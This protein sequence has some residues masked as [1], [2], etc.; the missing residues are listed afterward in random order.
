VRA[1]REEQARARL[2]VD[3]LQRAAL[4]AALPTAPA[5]RFDAEYSPATSELVVGGDWYDVIDVGEGRYALVIA[6]VA[7]HGMPAAV[8]MVQVRNWLHA[9]ALAVGGS[10]PGTV[11]TMLNRTVAVL[12]QPFVTCC[13]AVVDPDRDEIRWAVAGH[14][15]PLVAG[16]KSCRLLTHPAVGPPLGVVV[17][18]AYRTS[19][20]RLSPGEALVLY[21]D[22][23]VERREEPLDVGFERLRQA[24]A[25]MPSDRLS[26]PYLLSALLGPAG[27]ADDVAVVLV[28]RTAATA[29]G[30]VGTEVRATPAP[31]GGR[32]R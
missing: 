16:P 22:G 12:D 5:L 25:G 10:D 13:M 14:P 6:D 3:V 19:V 23:L 29:G 26:A 32:R 11:L 1:A 15:P 20:D 27:S 17:G 7:G 18:A 24:C 2:A 28:Q 9:T 30:P 4:P 8:Y 21:T 31:A